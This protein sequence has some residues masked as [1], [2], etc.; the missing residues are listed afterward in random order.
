MARNAAYIHMHAVL[1][2]VGHLNSLQIEGGLKG[3]EG[4]N[5]CKDSKVRTST[6]CHRSIGEV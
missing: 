5:V 1:F 4:V 2:L 3:A 6:C